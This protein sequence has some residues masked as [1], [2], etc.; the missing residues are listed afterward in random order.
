M[1][2]LQWVEF[3]MQ[4]E[5]LLRLGERTS[6]PHRHALIEVGHIWLQATPALARVVQ[7]AQAPPATTAVRLEHLRELL[8][9]RSLLHRLRRLPL[10]QL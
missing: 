6:R 10:L 5:V 3:L 9:L 1:T 8:Q 2:Y 7:A 4:Q